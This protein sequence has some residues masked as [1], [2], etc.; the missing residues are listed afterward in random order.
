MQVILNE[1]C[2][3]G[4]VGRR[5]TAATQFE[6]QE[7]ELKIGPGSKTTGVAIQPRFSNRTRPQGW[8]PP[9][10][11]SRVGNI[12]VWATR[13]I[14]LAPVT[15]IEIET[16]KFDTQPM[17]NPEISGIEYQQGELQGP[18]VRGCLLEKFAR[19]CVY[20]GA[21]GVPLQVEHLTPVARGG[22]NSANGGMLH[23]EMEAKLNPAGVRWDGMQ[24]EI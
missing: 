18:E 19:T 4:P 8:L 5:C 13:L 22:S 21:K 16:S 10:L 7:V 2:N 11:Q 1:V 6:T 9:S 3:D 12:T 15:S 23:E 14:E 20:C 24:I 17:A